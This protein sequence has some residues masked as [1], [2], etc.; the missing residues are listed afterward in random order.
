MI[1][2]LQPSSFCKVYYVINV[3]ES[4]KDSTNTEDGKVIAFGVNVI[5][6]DLVKT[7]AVI[8]KTLIAID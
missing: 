1:R 4:T 5:F 3:I 2:K 8:I 7:R 6:A